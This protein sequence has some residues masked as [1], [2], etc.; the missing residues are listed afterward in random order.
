V[1]S[2]ARHKINELLDPAEQLR[3]EVGVGLH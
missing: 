3:F 1:G 2:R